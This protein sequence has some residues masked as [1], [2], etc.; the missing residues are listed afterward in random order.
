M[1][2]LYCITGLVAGGLEPN[3]PIR[4]TQFLA[5][6]EDESVMI[7]SHC[8]LN[9]GRIARKYTSYEPEITEKFLGVNKIQ[10]KQKDL[11]LAYV[12]DAF[13]GFA[14]HSK[15]FDEITAFVWQQLEN[16]SPKARDAAQHYLQRFELIS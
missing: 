10:H 12:I 9:S 6:L 8:A 14:E 4:I 15:R 7:A 5:M 13:E 1:V 11:I 16:R 3:F 2:S